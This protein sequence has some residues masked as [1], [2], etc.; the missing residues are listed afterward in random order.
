MTRAPVTEEAEPAPLEEH[1]LVC[2]ECINRTE[3]AGQYIKV[4]R[5]AL[6]S[7]R[8]CRRCARR[9]AETGIIEASASDKVLARKARKTNRRG[10]T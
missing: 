2:G 3:K 4:K 9:L 1:L 7:L 5:A 8:T 10:N 6:G